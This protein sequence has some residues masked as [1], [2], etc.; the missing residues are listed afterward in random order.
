MG[1]TR[2][3]IT[4]ISFPKSLDE[5]LYFMNVRGILDMEDLLESSYVEWT[6]P[7]TA[8]VGDDV[9]FMHAVTSM[10]IIKRLQCELN[11]VKPAISEN[12]YSILKGALDRA[13]LIYEKYGAK[14][15]ATGKVCDEIIKDTIAIDDGLHWRSIYYVPIDSIKILDK[16]VDIS[17]FRDFIRVS[18][19]GAITKLESLQV[20]KLK[21]LIGAYG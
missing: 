15:F 2:A 16:P 9:F 7:K 10:D 6:A 4:N 5:V 20:S 1:D 21:A 3:F 11:E 19:T 12:D 18:R 8:E 14:I 13:T 17:K